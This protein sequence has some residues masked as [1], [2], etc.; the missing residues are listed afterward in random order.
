MKKILMLALLHDS[1][2]ISNR[3]GSKFLILT[4]LLNMDG[5]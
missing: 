3:L 2:F 1:L 5:F 4:M